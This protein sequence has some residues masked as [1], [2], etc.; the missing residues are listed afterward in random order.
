MSCMYRLGNINEQLC[1][2]QLVCYVHYSKK[3]NK[4][5]V[6]YFLSLCTKQFRE[7]VLSVQP[8]LSL[9][10]VRFMKANDMAQIAAWS[11]IFVLDKPL[12]TVTLN[13]P[14]NTFCRE[15]AISSEHWL[16]PPVFLDET[17]IPE[18]KIIVKLKKHQEAGETNCIIGQN[19]LHRTFERQRNV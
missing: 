17:A 3:N 7:Y 12:E 8:I 16:L 1:L 11:G 5:S 2:F 14:V 10:L 9:S 15:A 4:H 13:V 6:L 19:Y 18:W